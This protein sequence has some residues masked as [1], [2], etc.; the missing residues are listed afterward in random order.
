[1]DDIRTWIA[2]VWEWLPKNVIVKVILVCWAVWGNMNNTVFNQ[3]SIDPKTLMDWVLAYYADWVKVRNAT[4]ISNIDSNASTG[5]R[6]WQPP[7]HD[8]WK[9]NVDVAMDY[10]N[11]RMGFGWV[12][13]GGEGEVVGVGWRLVRGVFS[14][15]EAEAVGVREV[16]SWVKG[17]GW[18]RVIVETDA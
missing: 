17:K 9:I 13:R 8:F 11:Y 1:M 15:R 10:V 3:Q 12:V 2:E 4:N 5:L 6:H 7:L 14:V 18:E 16:L